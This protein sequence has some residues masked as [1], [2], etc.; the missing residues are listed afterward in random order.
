MSDLMETAATRLARAWKEG[1]PVTP[2]FAESAIRRD[3]GYRIQRAVV[4]LLASELGPRIGWKL[5]LMGR[6]GPLVPFAGPL[7]ET[8]RVE[9]GAVLTLANAI[10]PRIEVELAII[11]LQDVPGA[12]DPADDLRFDVAPAFEIIDDRTIPPSTDAD[13][14]ADLATVRQVVFGPHR[15]LGRGSLDAVEA[16]LVEDDQEVGRGRVAD[17]IHHPLEGVAWLAH[18]LALSGDLIRAGEVIITGSLTGQR[19]PRRGASYRGTLSGVGIVE[20]RIEDS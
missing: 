15:H 7:H 6:P 4:D 11:P 18:H 3:A 17:V 16:V 10:V 9:N 2:P 1:V 13:W 5:G 8:M 20:T 19:T 14:I 12:Y